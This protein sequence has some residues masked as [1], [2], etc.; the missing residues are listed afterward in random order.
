M[1]SK[2]DIE[3]AR[4]EDVNLNIW[5][6]AAKELG[7]NLSEIEYLSDLEGSE[8][9]WDEI[10]SLLEVGAIPEKFYELSTKD[11]EEYLHKI[12]VKG[13]LILIDYTMRTVMGGTVSI[14]IRKA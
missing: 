4:E 6:R 2:F 1:W 9:N 5:N 7:C 13:G 11:S 3:E 14:Y 8:E 12:T 10:D